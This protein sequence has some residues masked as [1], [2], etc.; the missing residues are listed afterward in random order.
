MKKILKKIL[1]IILL[2]VMLI[3]TGTTVFADY[4]PSDLT[5]TL[6]Q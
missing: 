6:F 5:G 2:I 3:V 1:L 4:T